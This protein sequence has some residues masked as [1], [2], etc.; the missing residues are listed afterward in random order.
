MLRG[1]AESRDGLELAVKGK[2][3]PL[4]GNELGLR[5][6]WAP[7]SVGLSETTKVSYRLTKHFLRSTTGD[8][9]RATAVAGRGSLQVCEM[10]ISLH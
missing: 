2:D 8:K 3:L 1:Y 9:N 7:C 4:P 10:Y 5:Y 6:I